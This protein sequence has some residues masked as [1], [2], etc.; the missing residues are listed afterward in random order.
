MCADEN[1]SEIHRIPHYKT[2][3]E[4]RALETRVAPVLKAIIRSVRAYLENGD[5]HII[6]HA[7][8]GGG[9]IAC[10]EFFVSMLHRSPQMLNRDLK[11][12]DVVDVVTQ[13]ADAEGVDP[14]DFLSEASEEIEIAMHSAKREFVGSVHRHVANDYSDKGLAVIAYSNPKRHFIVG[15]RGV[16]DRLLLPIAPDIAIGFQDVDP[17]ALRL[18]CDHEYRRHQANKW[19]AENS[20]AIAGSSRKLVQK[21][22]RQRG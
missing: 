2:E 1:S 21:Y 6:S 16:A 9:V 3:F 14:S 17:N 10:M 19:L 7:L 13:L 4:L 8:D 11:E 20:T 15:S 5:K 18:Y 12:E 22:A